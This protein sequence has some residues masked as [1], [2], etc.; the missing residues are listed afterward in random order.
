MYLVYETK[1]VATERAD[2]EGRSNGYAYW[3]SSGV[4]RWLTE[5]QLAVDGKW[6]LDVS[7]YELDTVEQSSTEPTYELAED[8]VV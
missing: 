4:T 1:E 3:T 8:T 5:P 6:V 7:A 2:E